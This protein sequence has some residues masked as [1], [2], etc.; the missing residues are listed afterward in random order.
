MAA[1]PPTAVHREDNPLP[2]VPQVYPAS[3][4]SKGRTR[5]PCQL[6]PQADCRGGVGGRGTPGRTGRPSL[7]A[8]VPQVIQPGFPD[9]AAG[10]LVTGA[11][12]TW[13]GALLQQSSRRQLQHYTRPPPTM[14]APLSRKGRI[15]RPP[16][17]PR[18]AIFS[19][20]I[21]RNK[22]TL[23]SCVLACG[24]PTAVSTVAATRRAA[25][26][27][28]LG[29]AF[30]FEGFV[31][32][33]PISRGSTSS[34]CRCSNHAVSFICMVAAMGEMLRPLS[35]WNQDTVLKKMRRIVD[36]QHLFSS[37]C[38]HGRS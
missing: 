19:V 22:S 35:T 30:S 18:R 2:R 3:V 5:A 21:F 36:A 6:A 27:H 9:G 33:S 25:Q 1:A 24:L 32:I 13:Q 12:C 29:M 14:L 34:G 10:L 7:P 17:A 26:G 4:S 23:A 16:L 8:S 38:R 31:A 20:M 11:A 28:F 37:H 15:C